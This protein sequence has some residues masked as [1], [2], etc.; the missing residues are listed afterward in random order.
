MTGPRTTR[1]GALTLVG[2][3][4]LAGCG[5]LPVGEEEPPTLD[6]A[7][8]RS[9]V[10]E[11]DPTVAGTFPVDLPDERLSG[12]LDRAREL[13]ADVPDRLGPDEVP[14][15]AV[16][17]RMRRRY[18]DAEEAI[19]RAVEAETERE[20]LSEARRA[21]RR[22]MTVSA[23]W[24]ATEGELTRE[25]VASESGELGEE[26][27]AV[28]ERTEY[29][30]DDPARAAVVH[31]AIEGF[32][33]HAEGRLDGRSGPHAESEGVLGVGELAGEHEDARALT[34]DAATLYDA[35]VESLDAETDIAAALEDAATSLAAAL[36]DAVDERSLTRGF[37]ASEHMDR[38]VAGTPAERALEELVYDLVGGAWSPES[39]AEGPAR[40]VVAA[41]DG[42]ASLDAFDSVRSRIEDGESFAVDD[43][44][45]VEERRRAAVEAVADAAASSAEPELVAEVVPDPARRVA[46]A[47][48][49]LT[50]RDGDVRVDALDRPIAEYVAAAERARALP[51]AAERVGVELRS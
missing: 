31:A 24:R 27:S 23:A 1:R 41:V 9:A 39:V 48:E 28:R 26:L 13:L 19:R 29:V 40:A 45:D 51:E 20:L 15:G 43:A 47:D 6:G 21:R 33:A 12:S 34:A 14:N 2:G 46:Y 4:A 7:A 49:R 8:L 25:D 44:G 10:G 35:F 50:H 17:E 36:D 38:D 42:F 22:S 5:R 37:D 3:V 32:T 16:R 30:G 18:G 11:S